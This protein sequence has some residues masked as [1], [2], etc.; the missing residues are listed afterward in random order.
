[1]GLLGY[2]H[3]HLGSHGLQKLTFFEA[4]SKWVSWDIP[5]FIWVISEYESMIFSAFKHTFFLLGAPIFIRVLK[6]SA[7]NCKQ[8]LLDLESLRRESRAII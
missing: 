7:F 6:L 4:N 5:I 2:L 1:M 3:I 8:V